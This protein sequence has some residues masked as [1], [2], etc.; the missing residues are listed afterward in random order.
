MMVARLTYAVVF[1]GAWLP[2]PLSG[3][4]Y[5]RHSGSREVATRARLEL[6]TDG[7]A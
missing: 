1:G 6:E 7:L 2:L 4:M 5:P 3:F